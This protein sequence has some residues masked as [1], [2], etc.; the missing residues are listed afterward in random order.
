MQLL[1]KKYVP[2]TFLVIISAFWTYFYQSSTLFNDSGTYKPEWLLLIDGLFVLPLLCFFCIDN[3]KEA[4]IKAIAYACIVVLIG[5]F[6]IPETSKFVWHYLES[7]RYLVLVA[8]LILE[9]ATLATVILAI[10]ASLQKNK[11][12]DLSI[13]EPIEKHL[14]TTAISKILTFE[15][16]VWTY[17]LFA[18]KVKQNHFIGHSHFYGHNKDGAQSNQLGFILVMAFELPIMHLI[19]HFVWSPFAANVTTVLT[20]I[21][22]VFLIAE[23]K[24]LALRPT[25]ICHNKIIV[26]YSVWHPFE[27]NFSKI[28]EISFNNEPVRK[29]NSIQRFNL[30]GCPNVK[31]ELTTGEKI[32]LGLNNPNEFIDEVKEQLS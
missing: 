18:R 19:L 15:A 21:S 32:Y 8:F 3:K 26:R 4:T 25:S 23:Y 17:F 31:I 16:R 5:S 9:L 13:S 12:P 11:D 2:F 29:A 6:I 22:F 7:S 14:G 30:S 27:I 24:A 10:K 1:Q 20:L 28:K